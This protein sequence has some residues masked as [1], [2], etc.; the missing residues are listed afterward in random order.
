MNK[1]DSYNMVFFQRSKQTVEKLQKPWERGEEART[2][3][4]VWWGRMGGDR[5]NKGGKEEKYGRGRPTG[6]RISDGGSIPRWER[7]GVTAR[8]APIPRPSAVKSCTFLT[9]AQTFAWKGRCA[10]THGAN[11]LLLKTCITA[12]PLPTTHTRRCRTLL[13]GD[14]I[15]A[16]RSSCDQGWH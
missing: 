13:G 7:R 10:S 1:Y 4:W 6:C 15:P 16:H 8:W 12:R 14:G 11:G 2:E 9:H 5:E 3:V